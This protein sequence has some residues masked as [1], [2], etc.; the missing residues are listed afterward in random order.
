M[1]I[2]TDL[3]STTS[4]RQ[5]PSWPKNVVIWFFDKD[6]RVICEHTGQ[7]F[8]GEASTGPGH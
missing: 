2:T 7:Q 4:L 1:A 3:P 6:F 5:S 8:E